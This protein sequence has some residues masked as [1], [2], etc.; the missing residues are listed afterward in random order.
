[1]K[2]AIMAEV[3]LF[4]KSQTKYLGKYLKEREEVKDEYIIAK[5]V[6]TMQHQ[7][8]GWL[9]E[10]QV[11]A[12]SNEKIRKGEWLLSRTL[13]KGIVCEADSNMFTL[14]TSKI[15][16]SDKVMSLSRC[17]PSEWYLIGAIGDIR[18]YEG[19]QKTLREIL[20]GKKKVCLP[21]RI[22]K[23]IFFDQKLD[24]SQQEAVNMALVAPFL[25]LHG[26]AGSGKTVTLIE[27]I[28][29]HIKMK[30]KILVV[31]PTHIATDNILGRLLELGQTNLVR[32]GHPANS[33][34]PEFTLDNVCR[35]QNKSK[36]TVLHQSSVVLST[37][38]GCLQKI[39]SMK[40]DHFGLTIVE[41]AGQPLEALVWTIVK[42]SVRLI[43]AGDFKQ[44]GPTLMTADGEIKRILGTSI[45]QRISNQGIGPCVM[46]KVQYR[47][48]ALI[49]E[50]PNQQFYDGKLKTAEKIS[51]L[52]VISLPKIMVW[53]L[54]S[55][56][57]LFLVDT[58]GTQR[59]GKVQ[60]GNT[61]YVHN[62]KEAASVAKLAKQLLR[63]GVKPEM[64]G[65]VSFYSKQVGLLEKLIKTTIYKGVEVKTIDGFQGR[66]KEVLLV[67][68]VRSNPE[69]EIG[70]LKD[71]RRWN[72]AVTRAK[73]LLVVVGDVS[74]FLKEETFKSFFEYMKLNGDVRIF[75]RKM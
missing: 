23:C 30:V 3:N 32:L 8:L 27:V 46:L 49:A 42:Y 64:L 28:R 59:E 15:W 16:S 18:N 43:L 7:D 60:S 50:W 1:M 41:E 67:S 22:S 63:S 72:V 33:S 29:Q 65:I 40:R 51:S 2:N 35:K 57:N 26:P 70:F 37:L 56:K 10:F 58:N 55:V 48:A 54:P 13:G 24:E 39:S 6:R 53:R 34:Y 17:R 68:M 52:S 21:D 75:G 71:S 66:E 62:P 74:T 44:L 45:I 38:A 12:N 11:E 61:H 25:F 36:K 69:H 19:A 31:T 9:A 73:R 14:C 47:M 20:L 5:L 4:V